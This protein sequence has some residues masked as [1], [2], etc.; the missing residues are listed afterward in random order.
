[1]IVNHRHRFVFVHI[2][3]TAGTSLRAALDTLEGADPAAVAKTWHETPLQFL[4]A[5]AERTGRP[6]AELEGYRFVAFVRNPWDRFGSLHRF[7]LSPRMR[8]RYPEVPESLVDF[9]RMAVAPP[10][11]MSSIR[12]LRPQCDYLEG[13]TPWTGRFETLDADFARLCELLGVSLSLPA[14]KQTRKAAPA[15]RFGIL[16]RRDP[17]HS[18]PVRDAVAQLYAEDIARF[19]Y[20]PPGR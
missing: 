1:M 13:I 16:P 6:V 5:Y 19:G 7:L 10:A 14:L 2:P 8:K 9:A 3:K 12:S 4:D 15:R 17:M 11:W 18:A 20:A